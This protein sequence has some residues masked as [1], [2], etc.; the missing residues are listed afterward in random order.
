MSSHKVIIGRFEY[1]DVMRTLK[2]VPA[3]IDTG[4]HRSS[5]HAEDIQLVNKGNKEL[6][7][8]TL[9]NHGVYKKKKTVEVDK[10]RLMPV[11]SSNGHITK[12]YEVQLRIKLGYKIFTSSFTLSDRSQNVFPILIGRKALRRR[13]LVDSDVTA[14]NRKELRRAIADLPVDEEDLDEMEGINV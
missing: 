8:F 5:I 14:V 12:R 4:A 1:V 3:K 13:F 11:R 6:L 2:N 10:F 7:R 9:L